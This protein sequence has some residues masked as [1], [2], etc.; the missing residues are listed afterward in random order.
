MKNARLL[1]LL[2]DSNNDDDCGKKPKKL[3]IHNPNLQSAVCLDNV[4]RATLRKSFFLSQLCPIYRIHYTENADFLVNGKH[5]VD[6]CQEG[7]GKK[8]EP[9]VIVMEDMIERGKG[10]IIPLWLAGFTY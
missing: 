9:S 4:D 1:T 7:E 8:K 10:N 5:E 2:Y 6:V 3:Y